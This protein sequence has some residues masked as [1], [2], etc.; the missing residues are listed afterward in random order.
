[1]L[2]ATA[3]AVSQ[4]IVSTRPTQRN[5]LIEEYTGVGCT[6]CPLGHKAVDFCLSS[7]PG[8]AFAIN[9][10]QG[11]FATQFT[12]NW[13]NALANQA[14]VMGYPSAT[15]SRHY[16]SASSMHIDPGQSYPRALE[17]MGQEAPVNVAATVDID[18]VSRLMLVKVE[19]Y[20]PGNGP[21]SFNMLNVALVQNNVLGAQAGAS[22]YY[23]ENMVNG[24]YCHNHI[25]RHLITGQWGDTIHNVSAGSFFSKEYAYVVP[26]QI[27]DLAV[28][29]LKD[30]SVIVFVCKDRSEVLNVC[31]AVPTGDKAYIAYGAAGGEECSLVY[32]PYVSVVNPTS[33]PVTGIRLDVGGRQVVSGKTIAPYCSDTVCVAEYAIDDMPA[34]HQQYGESLTVRLA[35][36]TAGGSQVDIADEPVTLHYAN[37][38]IYSVSGPL[39]LS[40]GYDAYP[41]EVS[42]SLAGIEDCQ[43]YYQ[44]RG[45]ESDA[46]KTVTYTLSPANAG[47]Y[48]LKLIDVGADGMSGTVTVTDGTGAVVF[49]RNAKDL[50]VWDSYYFNILNPGSDGPTGSVVG[51]DDPEWWVPEWSVAPNPT[52]DWLRINS[53]FDYRLAEV[54]DLGGRVRL[55]TSGKQLDVSALPAGVYLLRVIA[56]RGV[57]TKKFV[58]Q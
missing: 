16:F 31:E 35:G 54:V 51:I 44:V 1:M 26:Y 38:D 11:M 33:Q 21:G 20:Y 42:F 36:Y 19:A 49:S 37:A 10:H 40:I 43:Y 29:N 25:L 57:S 9:I 39:T 8:R 47:L 48:R 34:T 17:L 7:F 27:G 13:G 58:K 4:T 46:G 6:Y 2:M 55:A 23:P 28:G 5:V 18:P 14:G 30:L 53:D 52:S 24:Q 56:D 12:T 3:I 15:L 45:S 22:Q 41:Q 32:R 50:L